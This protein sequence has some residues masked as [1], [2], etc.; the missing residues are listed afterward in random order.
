MI[1]NYLWTV[2]FH[3]L[4]FLYLY[5]LVV[6]KLVKQRQRVFETPLLGLGPRY[7][8]NRYPL[9][10]FSPGGSITQGFATTLCGQFSK[11]T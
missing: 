4:H 10:W 11:Y 3:M 7:F 8:F 6:G 5:M 1:K 2:C 9:P